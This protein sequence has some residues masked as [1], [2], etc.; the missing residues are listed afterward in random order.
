M[1]VTTKSLVVSSF[2]HCISGNMYIKEINRWGQF[3][4]IC[5]HLHTHS[6]KVGSQ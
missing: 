3:R 6:V 2:V 4:H 1:L 5:K